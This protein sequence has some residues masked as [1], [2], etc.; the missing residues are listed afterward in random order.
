MVIL[1]VTSFLKGHKSD[2]RMI[3]SITGDKLTA[4][5]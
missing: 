2:K 4:L 3:S 1:K 5:D